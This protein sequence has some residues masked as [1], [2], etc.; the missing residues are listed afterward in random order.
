MP[1]W[2]YILHCADGSYYIGHTDD[3]EH[4]IEQH[5]SGALGRYPKRRRPVRVV[6]SQDFS[7]RDEAFATERQLKVWSRK[8]KE[9]LIAGDWQAR[10]RLARGRQRASAHPLTGSG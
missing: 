10:R 4:H 3:L 2:V 9:A 5:H 7:T 8:K 1:F 6:Y